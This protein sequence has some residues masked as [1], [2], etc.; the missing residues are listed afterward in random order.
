VLGVLI[1]IAVA[2]VNVVTDEQLGLTLW[3]AIMLVI[4]LYFLLVLPVWLFAGPL[5]WFSKV[6]AKEKLIANTE[7]RDVSGGA[8]RY[9][10]LE[11]LSGHHSE[12]HESGHH[13]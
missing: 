7:L 10:D 2:I 5:R 3:A 4:S 6:T 1:A 9:Q 13:H 11:D 12:Q 8:N